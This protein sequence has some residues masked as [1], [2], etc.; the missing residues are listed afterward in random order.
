MFY[1]YFIWVH[2]EFDIISN[3]FGHW[4][5]IECWFEWRL[6]EVWWNLTWIWLS[7]W[8][9]RSSWSGWGR[10]ICWVQLDWT[11]KATFRAVWSD[12]R[13]C[14]LRGRHGSCHSPFINLL[15]SFYLMFY[16]MFINCLYIVYYMFWLRFV[17]VLW[18]FCVTLVFLFLFMFLIF[19]WVEIFLL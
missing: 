17:Y 18:L 11:Y 4:F 2:F 12:S 7:W 8:T 9:T 6:S 5:Y 13:T 14:P 3:S 1:I 10:T 15:S 16:I 19:F